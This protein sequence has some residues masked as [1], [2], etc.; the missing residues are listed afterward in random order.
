V[1]N[2]PEL[3]AGQCVPDFTQYAH[4]HAC[5][6]IK[7]GKET[8]TADDPRTYEDDGDRKTH[9]VNWATGRCTPDTAYCEEFA[10]HP[11]PEDASVVCPTDEE[12]ARIASE[13][14]YFVSL[15]PSILLANPTAVCNFPQQCEK[16]RDHCKGN[17]CT[18]GKPFAQK[19]LM[20]LGA[21]ETGAGA[22]TLACKKVGLG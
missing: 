19:V 13:A 1:A 20:A 4:T 10:M 21:G 22:L 16:K 11:E 7:S 3:E 6:Y 17:V 2:R 14:A 9:I 18:C 12:A 5:R 8:N 15:M